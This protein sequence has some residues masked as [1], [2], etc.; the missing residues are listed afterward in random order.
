MASRKI[1]LFRKSAVKAGTPGDY[2]INP[3]E[4]LMT[5]TPDWSAVEHEDYIETTFNM[6][7]FKGPGE[8]VCFRKYNNQAV[9]D[10]VNK[11]EDCSYILNSDFIDFNGM[12]GEVKDGLHKMYFPKIKVEDNKKKKENVVGSSSG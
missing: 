9:G 4:K 1:H 12:D 10:S 3:S 2:Y 11:A 5:K 7:A 8:F 6:A